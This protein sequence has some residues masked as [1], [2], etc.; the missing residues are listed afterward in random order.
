MQIKE[1]G[2]IYQLESIDGECNQTI[3]FVNRVEG[4]EHPGTLNQD[5]IRILIDRVQYLETE[6]HWDGND[7]IIHHLRMAL[8]LH[9]ARVLERKTQQGKIAPEG[10]QIDYDGH[11]KLMVG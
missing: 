3:M 4:K 11:F 9:E 10:I 1:R 8:V 7:K 5:V 6:V 2:H